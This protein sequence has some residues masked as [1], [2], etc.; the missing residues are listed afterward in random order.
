MDESDEDVYVSQLKELFAGCDV[1][2]RGV[3]GAA[4]LTD[5]CSKLQLEGQVDL[6]LEHLLDKDASKMVSTSSR[7]H[8]E[9]LGRWGWS[10]IKTII[11]GLENTLE[12]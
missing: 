12:R 5:L 10:D 2:G 3:L 11:A 9:G 6:L 4:E 1:K 8:L 7:M